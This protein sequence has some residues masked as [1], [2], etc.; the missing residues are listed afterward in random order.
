MIC[1]SPL[2]ICFSR[3]HHQ[4]DKYKN[5]KIYK[6]KSTKIHKY[7]STKLQNKSHIQP[8]SSVARGASTTMISSSLLSAPL[9]AIIN[10][11]PVKICT[12]DIRQSSSV[13]DSNSIT[14]SC[15]ALLIGR[16]GK[17]FVSVQKS[18]KAEIHIASESF[19]FTYPRCTL[20]TFWDQIWPPGLASCLLRASAHHRNHNWPRD[21]TLLGDRTP[22]LALY[23]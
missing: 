5:A 9:G 19:R 1:S 4:Q 8:H 21:R 23:F 11:T 22:M 18:I 3:G 6:L 12:K 13:F 15:S 10:I 20:L 2:F 7:K 14:L 16:T 17:K